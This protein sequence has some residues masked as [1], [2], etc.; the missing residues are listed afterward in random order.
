MFLLVGAVAPLRCRQIRGAVNQGRPASSSQSQ[1][2]GGR[3]KKAAGGLKDHPAQVR[4]GGVMVMTLWGGPRP[5]SRETESSTPSGTKE[6]ARPCSASTWA[7]HR[8]QVDLSINRKGWFLRVWKSFLFTK[9]AN[10]AANNRTRV[11]FL[12]CVSFSFPSWLR[13]SCT[14]PRATCQ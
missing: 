4:R 8:G 11:H 10:K 9:A 3:N 1:P 5:L 6:T 14:T 12:L 7:E 13:A 2:S